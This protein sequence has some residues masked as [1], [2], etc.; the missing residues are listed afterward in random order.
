MTVS[1]Q[2]VLLTVG[3]HCVLLTVGG[4]VVILTVGGQAVLLTVGGP[5]VMLTVGGQAVLLTVGGPAVLLTV[6]Y[7]LRASPDWRAGR[8]MLAARLPSGRELEVEL[9]VGAGVSGTQLKPAGQ[10]IGATGAGASGIYS[11]YLTAQNQRSNYTKENI[12]F[13]ICY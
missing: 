3:G 1:G 8:L 12:L 13:F 11:Q 2:S 10:T 5:A 4:Q 6:P 9:E 7:M